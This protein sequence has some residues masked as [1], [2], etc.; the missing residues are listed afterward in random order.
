MVL[1]G[2]TPRLPLTACCTSQA[3]GPRQASQIEGFSPSVIQSRRATARGSVVGPQVHTR[4]KRGD[5][6]GVAVEHERR[7]L[8]KL[9]HPPLL[10]LAPA[11]MVYVRIHVGV[12]PVLLRRGDVPGG[13]RLGLEKP[14]FHDALAAL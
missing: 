11:R 12:E 6:I 9:A 5:L 8:E 13:P 10:G 1:T 7:A 4:V 14:N 3:A 2:S